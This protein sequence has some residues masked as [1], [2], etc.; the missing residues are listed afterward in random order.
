LVCG[1]AHNLK[2]RNWSYS[3]FILIILEGESSKP[4]TVMTLL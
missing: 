3:S 2:L 4:K 1:V